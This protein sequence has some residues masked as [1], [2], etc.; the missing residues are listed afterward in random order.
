MLEMGGTGRYL[1]LDSLA[2]APFDKAWLCPVTRRVLDTTFMGITPYLP[3]QA[4]SDRVA[5]CVPLKMPDYSPIA[6]LDDIGDQRLRSFAIGSI[7]MT[8][9]QHFAMRG[10]GPI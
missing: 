7:R 1:K 2:L 10:S 3:E 4:K 5:K 8:R 6:N 9:L